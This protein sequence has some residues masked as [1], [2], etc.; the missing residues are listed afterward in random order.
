MSKPDLLVERLLAHAS[1]CRRMAG[2][3]F[4]E[5]IAAELRKLAGECVRAAREMNCETG[6]AATLH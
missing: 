5:E 4:N 1:L 2:E 3:T 6:P